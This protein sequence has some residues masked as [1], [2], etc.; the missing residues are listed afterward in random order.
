[1]ATERPALGR[2]LAPVERPLR[3]I[4][5]PASWLLVTV[6]AIIITV[7]F[8][9]DQLGA[10]PIDRAQRLTGEWTLRFLLLSLAIT[11]L[12]RVTGWGWLITFRRFFGLSAFFWALSH[13]LEYIVLD[14][15][16][17][18]TEIVKDITKHWY[19]TLGMAAFLLLIPLALTSTKASI[20]RLGGKRW[21]ALHRL[22]YVSLILGCLHFTWAVKKDKSEPI[23][24]GAV[25]AGLLA[26]RLVGR[27]GR[28]DPARP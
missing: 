25:A 19:V 7:Q 4:A 17:D 5:W 14:Y 12:V 1:M 3:R 27:T 24:Y 18:W 2:L 6:P 23:L 28:R 8:L 22:V 13:L 15:F 26:F 11:P 10:D 20:K 16:F 9:T 21:T